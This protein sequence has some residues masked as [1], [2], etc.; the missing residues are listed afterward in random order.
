[1]K[2]ILLLLTLTIFTSLLHSQPE[3]KKKIKIGVLQKESLSGW[4]YDWDSTLRTLER[5]IPEHD[6]EMVEHSWTELKAMV[7]NNELDFVISSPVFTVE[8]G[9]HGQTTVLATL[10][11][12]SE[13]MRGFEELYGSVVFWRA[14]NVEIS[15]LWDIK[16]RRV[17]AGSSLSIGGWL[18]VAREFSERDIDLKKYC[19]LVSHFYE[20]E[21]VVEA[22]M[23]R[24]ADF[25]I[26]RTSTLEHMDENG[27]ID[28]D[29]L[30]ISNEFVSHNLPFACSTRLY[31]EWSF[32]RVKDTPISLAEKVT[33]AL[34]KMTDAI[35]PVDTTWGIPA[36][37]VSVRELMQSLLMEPFAEDSS[38]F[39]SA[40]KTL[41]RWLAAFFVAIII[42][43]SITFLLL[44]LNL[45]LRV[46]SKELAAQRSFLKQLID[47]IP[48]LIFVKK[49]NGRFLLC[50]KAFTESFLPGPL[51]DLASRKETELFPHGSP[52]VQGD[53]RVTQN[54]Q[55]VKFTR[56]FVLNDKIEFYGEVIKVACKLA[57]EEEPRIVGIVRDVSA[58]YRARQ[59]QKQREK[60][61]TGIA[62]AA[63]LIIGSEQPLH[64]AMAAALDS[65]ANAIEANRVGILQQKVDD[66]QKQDFDF[67]C[68]SC[69]HQPDKSCAP[70]TLELVCRIIR[71]S[72]SRILLGQIIG[73]SRYDFPTETRN[74]LKELGINSLLLMPVFVHRKFW[75]CMEVHGMN[76]NRDWQDYEIAALELAAEMFGS[77]IERS[78]DFSRLIDY[79]DRLRLAL[80]SAGLYLWEYEFSNSLNITPDD[81]YLN[82]GYIGKE[83]INDARNQGFNIIHPED[84][85]LISNISQNE[86]CQF[87]VRLQSQ[88]GKYQWHSFIG[89][90]YFDSS[91]RHLRLIGF[92]RNTS[93]EHE[94]EMALRMEE[95]RNVHAL[96]AASA[97]SWEFVPEEGRFYWSGHV[98]KLLGYS[99][100][101]FSPNI[102]SVFQVIHGDDL[103]AAEAAVRKFLVTGKELRF[104]CRLRKFDGSYSWFTNIGT[105]VKDPELDNV[106]YYGI[107]IDISENKILQQNWLEARN[108][109]EEMARRAQLASEAK[110]AFLANMSHEIRTPMNGI[111]GMLE[112][113]LATDLNSR[114]KEFADLIYRSSHS[115]LGI[116]N[117]ILDLSKIEAGKLTLEP[118]NINLKKVAEE[119]VSL[120]EPLAEKKEI[121]LVLRY[122]PEIPEHVVAD[123]GRIRQVL[124]NL[125][126]NAVK[127]TEQGFITI[128]ITSENLPEEENMAGF[129]FSVKDT[130]I[131]MN[132]E[133]QSLIFEKFSQADTSINRRFGGTGLG[134]TICKELITLMGGDIRLESAPGLGT[135][136]WFSLNLQLIGQQAEGERN[137]AENL[138]VIVASDNEPVRD[139]VCEI[140]ASW[141]VRYAKIHLGQIEKELNM[142][143]DSEHKLVMVVDF[144]ADSKKLKL[145]EMKAAGNLVGSIFLMTPKQLTSAAKYEVPESRI[146]VI[147][148]PV[149]DSKLYESIRDL[150]KGSESRINEY[151]NRRSRG[152][153]RKQRAMTAKFALR[154]LIVED[155]EINQEVA[156]GIFELFGCKSEVVDSGK[157]ALKIIGE[158]QF[159]AVFLDCQMPEM[160]GFE[161]IRRLRRLPGPEAK[162]PVVAVTAHSM[163]GDKEKCLNAGMDFYLS[164][165]INPDLLARILEKLSGTGQ[166]EGADATDEASAAERKA[167]LLILDKDRISRIFAKKLDR[168]EKIIN[169]SQNNVANQRR[170]VDEA[171]AQKDLKKA[172]AA[173]HTIKGSI[174]NLGGD[175]AAEIAQAAETAARAANLKDLKK[176]LKS[177]DQAFDH[178]MTEISDFYKE[179]Q[180]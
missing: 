7:V 141:N 17:A 178:F 37:Y 171:I 125:I 153:E 55:V 1:M 28:L 152:W 91:H 123:G 100:E 59:I 138:K 120:M 143:L 34:F 40:L 136:F 157:K 180:S 68:F 172:A 88:N 162:V 147:G 109:A 114:Q 131:G 128:E 103:P 36:N 24:K 92:F 119:V 99:P 175:Q 121:E 108:N 165:P 78:E 167:E 137:F 156:R 83:Q 144:P 151:F 60:L 48:D 49:P 16:N 117:A 65:I 111:L 139:T 13:K 74:K 41:R 105:Q 11:R 73:R 67:L 62:E 90:N 135:R 126:N 140:F 150:L 2:K 124:T 145:P 169:A 85:Y 12:Q 84:Q 174:G 19:A 149:T 118:V 176:E 110:T 10:K 77:M 122:P 87:E 71:E 95:S 42:L 96:T 115:L 52:F 22:V 168:L 113:L 127:F 63:H 14:D 6:F 97:A 9:F 44:K 75:G 132:D 53:D 3:A 8:A 58:N 159:D 177:F 23:T 89:R 101:I 54:G 56:K 81:L 104:D 154:V 158:E 61:I 146:A 46:V 106:R 179:L 112:L 39:M 173:L 76:E 57:Q 25:G 69:F 27:E 32:A 148:K 134:L 93:A 26:C 82:L 129:T 130:G 163:P 155:N 94:R 35:G 98:K 166:Q 64:Q 116:L 160:D 31:P 80:D 66:D 15:N 107:I 142:L 70:G 51:N 18:A 21:K 72:S 86:T 47:S 161:V 45:R 29:S 170:L 79:R 43:G 4:D 133:Q 164:K 102:E 50:N 38:F 20:N 33:I 30:R 5:E